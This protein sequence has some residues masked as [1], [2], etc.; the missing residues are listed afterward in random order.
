MTS[1]KPSTQ[2]TSSPAQPYVVSVFVPIF[3][4][5]IGLL[6]V[7]F[8]ALY[9][10]VSS[11]QRIR[12]TVIAEFQPTIIALQSNAITASPEIQ[13]DALFFTASSIYSFNGLDDP[14]IKSGFGRLFI[15]RNSSEDVSYRLEYSIPDQGEGYAGFVFQFSP[16]IDITEYEY[17]EITLSLDDP[18]ANCDVYLKRGG[19][20]NYI[21]ICDGSFL[22]GQRIEAA[23]SRSTNIVKIPLRLNFRD[24]DQTSVE[25][26]GFSA[27]AAFTRG[28]RAFTIHEVRLIK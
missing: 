15:N 23:T 26:I 7:I 28:S 10:N 22:N 3:V 5:I 18:N 11:E 24:I 6:G 9:N 14:K 2:S 20:A 8:T 17:L 25:E 27:N 16:A 13:N 4:A 1:K 19:I 12:Q 21:R